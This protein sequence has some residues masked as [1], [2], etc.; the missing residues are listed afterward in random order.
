MK[1][2]REFKGVW[3]PAELYLHKGLSWPEKLVILEVDSFSRNGLPCF[4]SNE[5]LTEVTQTSLSTVEKAIRRLVKEGYLS[6]TKEKVDGKVTRFLKVE[7]RNFCG[8]APV[9]FTD[10]QPYFLRP[11]NNS[12]LNQ[13]TKTKKK[14][15]PVNIE[16]VIE[17]F[18]AFESTELEA[19]KFYDYYSANGWKQNG[20]KAIVNW[21]AAARNWIRRAKEYSTKNNANGYDTSKI[22][23]SKLAEYV[24]YGR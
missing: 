22:D 15:T 11:T 2:R 23:A 6:R 7:A 12:I 19:Q 10:E 21:H 8:K 5:H 16:E 1:R 17:A 13:A 14:S 24:K 9:N 3:V 20:G 4:V 18:T